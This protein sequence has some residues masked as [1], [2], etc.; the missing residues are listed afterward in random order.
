VLQ[1]RTGCS[2]WH[3]TCAQEESA[4]SR[5]QAG[6]R[7]GRQGGP[8]EVRQKKDENE[9]PCQHNKQGSQL[10]L[11]FPLYC[12]SCNRSVCA[13]W[14]VLENMKAAT[15]IASYFRLICSAW[16]GLSYAAFVKSHLH[17][18]VLHC[19]ARLL[20]CMAKTLIFFNSF[21][22]VKPRQDVYPWFWKNTRI[23]NW[24]GGTCC[25]PLFC[26][27]SFNLRLQSLFGNVP[28]CKNKSSERAKLAVVLR[29]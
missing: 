14:C 26:A 27:E 1:R 25:A 24:W 10:R 2:G 20:H 5:E 15:F 12:T 23:S 11:L 13:K 17:F 4:R 7:A 19:M 8:T 21:G 6:H 28:S 22:I 9:P 16:L 3:R 18:F 29:W